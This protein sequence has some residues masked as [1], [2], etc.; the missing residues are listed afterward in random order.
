MELRGHNHYVRQIEWLENDTGLVTCGWDSS[1]FLWRLYQQAPVWEFNLRNNT[2][3]SVCA[4]I[5]P[6]TMFKPAVL[7]S[8]TDKAIRELITCP[9][10]SSVKELARIESESSFSQV[11]VGYQNNFCIAA[12]HQ[13]ADKPS[14][15]QIFKDSFMTK[16]QEVQV[17]SKQVQRMKLSYDNTKLIT[18]SEDGSIAF[19]T[20]SHY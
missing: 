5:S 20:L 7:A 12:C 3:N 17:H 1:V 4:Y 6:S 11:L 19:F 18:V 8:S 10:N 16:I 9:D 2:F 15:I 14:S 13:Q